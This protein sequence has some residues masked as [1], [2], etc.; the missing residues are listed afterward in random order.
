[1]IRFLK[2]NIPLSIKN[3]ESTPVKRH[4]LCENE[5]GEEMHHHAVYYTA[6]YFV[7]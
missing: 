1:M 5:G 6:L 7:I 4:V 2:R 3:I